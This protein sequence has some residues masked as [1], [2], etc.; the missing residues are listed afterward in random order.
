MPLKKHAFTGKHHSVR[1]FINW[2]DSELGC[3]DELPA[4][5]ID[6]CYFRPTEV[7]TFLGDPSGAK[8][9]LGCVPEITEQKMCAEMVAFDL[10]QVKQHA[11]LKANGYSVN[12]SIE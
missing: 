2:S 7:L 5:R 4:V 11:M 9:K 10:Q 6:P 8:E 3:W 12:F 1:Q